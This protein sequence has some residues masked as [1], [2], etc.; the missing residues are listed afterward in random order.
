MC[1][2]V[3][4]VILVRCIALL[5]LEGALDWNWVFDICPIILDL[6]CSCCGPIVCACWLVLA[7]LLCY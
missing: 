5:C 1:V 3:C 7:L 4:M 6:L 2:C